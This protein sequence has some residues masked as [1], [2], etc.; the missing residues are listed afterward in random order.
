MTS[1]RKAPEAVGPN[2]DP[3]DESPWVCG[4]CGSSDFKSV[5]RGICYARVDLS[6]EFDEQGEPI[7]ADYP[8]GVGDDADWETEGYFCGDCDAGGDGGAPLSK[9][10]VRRAAYEKGERK[11]W[12]DMAMRLATVAPTGCGRVERSDR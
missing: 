11:Q 5:E 7:V 6:D 4:N 8:Y 2:F 1:P 12:G 10:A 3:K 9:I